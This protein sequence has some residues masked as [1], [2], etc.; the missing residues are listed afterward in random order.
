MKTIIAGSRSITDIA[1]V[2]EA[3]RASG[4]EI[5]EVVCGEAAGVD[6]LGRWWAA[7]KKILI[8]SFPAD[9]KKE[10]RVA[11]YRRNQRMAAYADALIAVW[12]GESVGTPHMIGVALA[13]GLKIHIHLASGGKNESEGKHGV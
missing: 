8:A 10:G 3:V 9:W 1:Q 2:Y 7:Q 13:A 5:T 11:G 6:A 4:F 12:D